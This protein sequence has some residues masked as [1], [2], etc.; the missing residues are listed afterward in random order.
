MWQQSSWQGWAAALCTQG[1]PSAITMVPTQ[2]LSF[3]YLPFYL[4]LF[5]FAVLLRSSIMVFNFTLEEA[6]RN[7][8]QTSQNP[9]E[10]RRTNV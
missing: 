4:A 2:P 7:D 8:N 5:Q 10:A 3:L 1:T 6:F 9:Y